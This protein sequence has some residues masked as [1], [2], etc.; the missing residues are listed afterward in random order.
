[1]HWRTAQKVG[2]PYL[3]NFQGESEVGAIAPEEGLLIPQGLNT[4]R[5]G[6]T[7][8]ALLVL[9]LVKSQVTFDPILIFDGEAPKFGSGEPEKQLIFLPRP[10]NTLLSN[11]L[12]HTFTKPLR[13]AMDERLFRN[14]VRCSKGWHSLTLNPNFGHPCTHIPILLQQRPSSL[15]TEY[16]CC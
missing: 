16:H 15:H 1:M 6:L 2:S 11:V 4:V 14:Q 13:K 8:E 7:L 3:H 9:L 5:S 12:Y 10:N